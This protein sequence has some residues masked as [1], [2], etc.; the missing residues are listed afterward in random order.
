[1]GHDRQHVVEKFR[2]SVVVYKTTNGRWIDTFNRST[3]YSPNIKMKYVRTRH[4]YLAINNSAKR[5]IFF[6]VMQAFVFTLLIAAVCAS[7][8]GSSSASPAE[9]APLVVPITTTPIPILK[10]ELS[11]ENGSFV[12]K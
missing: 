10:Q 8:L 7:P 12:N 11:I 4:F 6:I 3:C 1:M 9:D 5:S 2:N